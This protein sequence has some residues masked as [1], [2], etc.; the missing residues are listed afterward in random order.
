[1]MLC[2][3]VIPISVAA[4]FCRPELKSLDPFF[5]LDEASVSPPTGFPDHPHRGRGII[6]S[7]IPAGPGAQKGLQLWVNL[8]SKDKMVEPNYQELLSED[9][10]KAEK[11]GVKVKIIAGESMGIK[12]PVYTR[13]PTM[14]LDFTLSP[15][16]QMHQPIPES[17]NSFVYVL[18]GE[19]V[20]GS[21]AEIEQAFQDYRFCK[22]GFEMA[23]HWRSQ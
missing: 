8:S 6:H 4:L 12:S 9:I 19:G 3:R 15:G 20:F 21:M 16:A 17:W 13:T 5:M 10:K 23:K 11:D 7:E 18:D 14:F 1:M 22:N 2:C